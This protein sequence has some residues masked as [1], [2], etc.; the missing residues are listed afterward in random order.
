M[1]S[2]RI[3]KGAPTLKFLKIMIATK[4]RE[5][6]FLSMKSWLSKASNGL[7]LFAACGAMSSCSLF[8]GGKYASQTEVETEVPESLEHG[9][10]S[11]GPSAS[12]AST[13]ASSAGVPAT[14]NL[15]DSPEGDP[16]PVTSPSTTSSGT[17]GKPGGAS[18]V[19]LSQDNAK[20]LIDIPK[21]E[22]NDISVHN[23]RPPAEMLSLGPPPKPARAV[24]GA[25][26]PPSRPAH[27]TPEPPKTEP[28]APE[29]ANAPAAL[30]NEPETAVPLLHS[31]G[32]L[33]DFYQNIHK[34]ILE[35]SA[36]VTKAP[37]G[38]P[39][40]TPSD[41]TLA[42]PPPPPGDYAAPPSIP[43]KK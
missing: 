43:P 7:A 3:S 2:K 15:I 1:G 42:V 28:A 10:P 16:P 18:L 8:G 39:A 4:R 27:E 35:S 14:S 36:A 9:K 30:K 40:T 31:G 41:E 6:I 17:P 19:G 11:K 23:T 24:L 33:S 21:P 13:Y 38:S 5:V 29:V 37:A 22:F 32:G 12:E 34:E 26:T 20:D 25:N